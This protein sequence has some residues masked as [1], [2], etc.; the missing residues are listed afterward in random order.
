MSKIYCEDLEKEFD[1]EKSVK[2]FGKFE[3]NNKPL[4]QIQDAYPDG[5]IENAIYKADAIDENGNLYLIIWE[6][7]NP[8][9]EDGSEACD[10]DNYNVEEY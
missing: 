4:Y 2:T 6:V 1:T 10:W 9:A 5:T 8:E 3:Y 7:I